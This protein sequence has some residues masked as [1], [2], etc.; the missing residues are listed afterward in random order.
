MVQFKGE[1]IVQKSRERP[2]N[3]RRQKGDMKHVPYWGPNSIR[4]HRTK[5]SLQGDMAPAICEPLD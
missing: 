4:R 3:I 5:F 1:Q 2:Q